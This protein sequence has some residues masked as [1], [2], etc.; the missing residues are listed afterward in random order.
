MA[1][2]YYPNPFKENNERVLAT[3][4]ELK[5]AFALLN[6]NN[7]YISQYLGDQGSA[8]AQQVYTHTLDSFTHL[9]QAKVEKIIIDKHPAYAVASLGTAYAEKNNIDS[10][11]TIQH[12]KAHFAA[13]LAENNLLHTARPILGFAWDG[14]GYGD[15]EQVWGSETFLFLDGKMKR[16]A[17]LAYFPVLLGDKMSKEPRLAALSL[18]QRFHGDQFIIRPWFNDT[19]WQYYQKLINS[20]HALFT[21]SM[22]RFLDG[23]ACILGIKAINTYE[24]EAAMQLEAM[25]LKCTVK[26]EEYYPLPLLNG[27]LDWSV[28]LTELLADLL[29]NKEVTV[30][31]WKV[32]NSLARCIGMVSNQLGINHIAFSGGVFQN[33]LLNELI[34]GQMSHQKKLY[35]HKQLSPND[36]C[37]GFGQLACYEL[38][39]NNSKAKIQKS[40]NLQPFT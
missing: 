21:S 18:L 15:D 40:K 13:V 8:D 33:A 3:G 2:N 11:V 32:F 27:I 17:H 4:G 26:P 16:V 20:E 24:G 29:H 10:P 34:V 28:F 5:A 37:I 23:I 39:L 12:H 36:E 25:A 14:T 19:E 31:A 38:L 35:F 7:L 6:K 9:M 30:I 22:G 1:P